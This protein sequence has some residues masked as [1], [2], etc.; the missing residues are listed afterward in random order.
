MAVKLLALISSSAR[1]VVV[2]MMVTMMAVQKSC[3]RLLSS[4]NVKMATSPA[5][6]STAMNSS[7]CCR[8]Q[9]TMSSSVVCAMKAVLESMNTRMKMGTIAKGMM[10]TCS[11]LWLTSSDDSSAKTMTS[12]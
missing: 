10:K 9:A 12:E 8:M 4:R 3:E 2:A 11:R 5:V 6:S 1:F 7:G